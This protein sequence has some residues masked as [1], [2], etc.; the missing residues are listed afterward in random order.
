MADQK[1]ALH[2][3]RRQLSTDS[4][5]FHDEKLDPRIQIELE[6][7]NKA[8]EEINKLELE[9]DDARAS[10]RQAL[11][12]STQKLNT[13]AKKLGACVEKARPY[14]DARIKAKDDHLET[15]KAALRY[16]RACSMHEAAKEMV[17]L[18]EQGYMRREQPSDPAWQEM[19]NHATMKVNEA[20]KERNES[21]REHERTT[22]N[23]KNSEDRVQQLQ[24]ELKRAITKSNFATRRHFLQLSSLANQ[25]WL[26]LLPYFEM[27]IKFNQVMEEQKINVSRLEEDVA[28]SKALYSQALHSL[29]A[30]SDEIHRQRLERRKQQQLGVRSAGVGAEDPS[31][32]P[33]WDNGSPHID[34]SVTP[35]TSSCSNVSLTTITVSSSDATQSMN[36]LSQSKVELQMEDTSKDFLFPSVIHPTA[37]KARTDSYRQA[38]DSSQVMSPSTDSM[39]SADYDENF[40]TPSLDEEYMNLPNTHSPRG[41]IVM[42]RAHV[43][44]EKNEE[45]FQDAQSSTALDEKS[46]EEESQ[47]VQKATSD[48][49]DGL[50]ERQRSQPIAIAG[51]RSH[52]EGV[53]HHPLSKN[54]HSNLSTPEGG[55]SPVSGSPSTSRKS[56][57]LQGL[58]LRIDP[59]MDPLQR[60]YSSRPNS[61]SST[62]PQYYPPSAQDTPADNVP[63]PS[64]EP[65]TKSIS[66]RSQ[67]EGTPVRAVPSSKELGTPGSERALRVPST[68]DMSSYHEDSSDTESIASAGPMIDDEQI[69]FLNLNFSNQTVKDDNPPSF[70]R[71]SWNRMS[72]PPRLSYL[73]GYVRKTSVSSEAQIPEQAETEAPKVEAQQL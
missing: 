18:A 48:A 1:E 23:F 16:E 2:Q 57:K 64:A 10:F 28:S 35:H 7:L 13:L 59:S 40:D 24:K 14:Y 22:I 38:I 4:E 19:L 37:D 46:P 32:P 70:R 71:Q 26:S 61:L 31:P 39:C 68:S 72:L 44:Q 62:P 54:Y 20:E 34:G 52:T 17:Q 11:S 73:E 8:T 6:K 30:I 51:I 15:Q 5:E 25:H 43:K 60:V 27:K 42:Q 55:N 9:L 41:R 36:T 65:V 50:S 56:P 58:I 67:S 49:T 3:I 12:D 69:E 53:L 29:E 33:S 66:S 21:E 47:K 63:E 45:V